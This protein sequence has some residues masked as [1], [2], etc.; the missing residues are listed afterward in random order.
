MNGSIPLVVRREITERLRARSFQI[1]TVIYLLISLASVV[2]PHLA[3]HTAPV[4]GI[5]LTGSDAGN[6]ERALGQLAPALD[7]KVR[8]QRLGDADAATTAVRTKAV[9]VALVDGE[10]IVSRNAPPDKLKALLNTTVYQVRLARQFGAGVGAL[11][12]PD[13][14]PE[15]RLEAAKPLNEKNKPL[16]FA[17]VI[18]IYLL[19]LT[20][21]FTVSNGVLEE[22]M[23]RVSE[24]LL[25]AVR[26]AQLL[27]GKVAGIGV[28]A[29]AQLLLVGVPTIVTA[30]VLGSF[31]FP[32]GTPLTLASVAMWALLGYGLYSCIFAAA[33][34]AASRPE[35]IGNAAAPI[36]VLIAATYFAAIA[37]I[38]APDGTA[39]KI[40]SFIPFMSPMTMLPRAAVGHVAWWEVPLSVAIVLITTYLTTR[41]GARVYA[42]GIRRPGPKLKLREAWRAAEA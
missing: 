27:A 13:P 31:H 6:V 20:Y 10:R 39:A 8:V 29:L 4:Y 26:P 25:V 1:S 18:I 9:D 35:D 5:G 2:V 30:L 37:S 12:A 22:K 41:L 17:G 24:V 38:Q 42:G 34:A 36:T 28:V 23:S 16:A 7:V 15:Q 40:V 21:G 14:L 32:S 33:G 3:K 19:L 11:P